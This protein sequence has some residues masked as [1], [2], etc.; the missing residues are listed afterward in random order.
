MFISMTAALTQNP[1]IATERS[2]QLFHALSD[3]TRLAIIEQL[4]GGER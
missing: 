3:V 4:Q 1:G 2:A